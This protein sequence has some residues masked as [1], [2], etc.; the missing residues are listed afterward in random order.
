MNIPSGNGKLEGMPAEHPELGK[1]LFCWVT[2]MSTKAL[3]TI[4]ALLFILAVI[5]TGY[6]AATGKF[7]L[8]TVAAPW[9]IFV[10]YAALWA[11]ARI[12]SGS[13]CAVY[14]EGITGNG[15]TIFFSTCKVALEATRHLTRVGSPENAIETS[16]SYEIRIFEGE[17]DFTIK[18]WGEEYGNYYVWFR[19]YLVP[20]HLERDR[21]KLESGET[22]TVG[23]FKID[24]KGITHS[25]DG[26]VT[27]EECDSFEVKNGEI[28]VKNLRIPLFVGGAHVLLELLAERK[29]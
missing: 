23:Q 12:P 4:L 21:K 27:W 2:P 15:K 5:T 16:A 28:I 1:L 7:S 3:N 13:P 29:S 8:S 14:Q 6:L 25:E 22:L 26:S 19:D 17:L 11:V 9:A 24:Q 20:R 18:G 10:L